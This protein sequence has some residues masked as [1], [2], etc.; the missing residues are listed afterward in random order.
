MSRAGPGTVWSAAKHR[1]S[2]ALVAV[3]LNS[4]WRTLVRILNWTENLW[5]KA[6]REPQTTPASSKKPTAVSCAKQIWPQAKKT[7]LLL[8]LVTLL[9]DNWLSWNFRC[10]SFSALVQICI[11]DLL[12]FLQCFGA[13]LHFRFVGLVARVVRKM[14]VMFSKMEIQNAKKYP[15]IF[16][17]NAK[18]HP[19]CRKNLFRCHGNQDGHR[20]VDWEVGIFMTPCIS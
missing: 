17:K 6:Y 10:S 4:C 9:N 2:S 18:Y 8:P 20:I 19:K 3:R 15:K 5:W 16:S 11:F 12:F 14:R 13:D 1:C 7:K